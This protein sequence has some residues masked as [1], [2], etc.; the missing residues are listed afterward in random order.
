MHV[1]MIDGW[2]EST[3]VQAEIKLA[4]LLLMDIHYIVPKVWR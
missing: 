1:Y 4:K 3:G 2:K